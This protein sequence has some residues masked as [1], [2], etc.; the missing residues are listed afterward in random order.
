MRSVRVTKN[1]PYTKRETSERPPKITKAVIA[2]Q[3]LGEIDRGHENVGQEY[4]APEVRLS[5]QGRGSKERGGIQE[6]S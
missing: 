6:V 3:K 4:T 5:C 2:Q 1:R